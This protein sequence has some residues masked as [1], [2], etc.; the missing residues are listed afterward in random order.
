MS[1]ET[2]STDDLVRIAEAGAGFRLDVVG[3]SLDDLVRIAKAASDWGVRLYFAG[4]GGY[5]TDDLLRIAAA[6]EGCVEF[7]A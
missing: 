2:R 4:V 7:E 6:G 3:R 5:S 1:F